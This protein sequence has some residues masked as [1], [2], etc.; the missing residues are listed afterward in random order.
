VV[1]VVYQRRTTTD[2]LTGGRTALYWVPAAEYR[3]WS[4]RASRVRDV[5]S[6]RATPVWLADAT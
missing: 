5:Q 2:P 6:L 1:T 3:V 4:R